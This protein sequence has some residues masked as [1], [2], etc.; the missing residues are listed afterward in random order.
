MFVFQRWVASRHRF[1]GDLGILCAW[2][3]VM[4]GSVVV[5]HAGAQATLTSTTEPSSPEDDEPLLPRC[6][7]DLRL[8]G[9]VYD[10]EHP[11][12]SFAVFHLA[13]NTPG[14]VYRLGM[15]V[16][17]FELVAVEP[18]GVVLRSADGE[19]WMRLVGAPIDHSRK[20]QSRPARH[21]RKKR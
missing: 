2:S 9:T 7:T 15:G 17:A 13:P 3:V 16:G 20:A 14:A 8:S 11:D 18:R 5:G 12:R 19:C 21:K 4:V 6:K 10:V 1:A